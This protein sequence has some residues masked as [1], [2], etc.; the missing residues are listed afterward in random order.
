M[1]PIQLICISLTDIFHVVTRAVVLDCN[2]LPIEKTK[3][4]S[5]L[6]TCHSAAHYTLP[7]ANRNVC[8]T[9]IMRNLQQTALI[10]AV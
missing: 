10:L 1:L 8:R 3:L 4:L 9:V 2:M 6:T 7:M 5:F